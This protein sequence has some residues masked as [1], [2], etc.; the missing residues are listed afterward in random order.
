VTTDWTQT[1][2]RI[3]LRDLVERYARAVDERNVDA[4]ADCF[5]PSAVVTSSSGD[6]FDGPSFAIRTVGVLA[7]WPVTHHLVTGQLVDFL[8]PDRA[9]GEVHGV[10]VQGD[11]SG[12]VGDQLVAGLRYLDAYTVHE[13]RWLIARR[14]A[15]IIWSRGDWPWPV[16]FTSLAAPD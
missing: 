11:S 8:G 2:S 9:Q 1:E 13:H 6:E 14:R 5:V 10:A 16:T 15:Q 7:R 3:E 4:V 12:H